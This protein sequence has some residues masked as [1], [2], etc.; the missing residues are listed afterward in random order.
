MGCT[1]SDKRYKDPYQCLTNRTIYIIIIAPTFRLVGQCQSI[2]ISGTTVW[3]VRVG[4]T[5]ASQDWLGRWLTHAQHQM[6]TDDLVKSVLLMLIQMRAPGRQNAARTN[7][8]H[9]PSREWGC[10]PT[11]ENP[12]GKSRTWTGVRKHT[13][14]SAVIP[15]E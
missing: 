3:A 8:R 14:H 10:D 11:S 12:P 4:F 15:Q 9:P 1:C 5:S 2:P 7:I 13:N 6:C